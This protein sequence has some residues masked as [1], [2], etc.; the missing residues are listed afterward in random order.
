MR[1]LRAL[2]QE[3]RQAGKEGRSPMVI[4]NRKRIKQ[5]DEDLLQEKEREIEEK[6]S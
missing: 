4:E 5:A 1:R 3:R 2:N 6:K